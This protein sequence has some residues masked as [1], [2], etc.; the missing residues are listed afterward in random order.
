MYAGVSGGESL[1]DEKIG[2]VRMGG[3]FIDPETYKQYKDEILRLSNSFQTNVQEH[4]PAGQ[5]QRGLSDSEI[6]ARLDLEER[7]VREIRVVA[8]RD[9]YPL[10][11]WER[12]IEF[13]DKACRAFAKHGNSYVFKYKHEL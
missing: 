1:P 10:D 9:Y 7:V 5:R 6:A 11:E 3:F 12:A 8:E 4:L 13:K 2:D